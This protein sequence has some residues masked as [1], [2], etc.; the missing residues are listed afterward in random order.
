MAIVLPFAGSMASRPPRA[1]R[2][3]TSRPPIW[4]TRDWHN[5]R[6]R[7]PS[8]SAPGPS[9]VE[10]HDGRATRRHAAV[11]GID[12]RRSVGRAAAD[13]YDKQVAP[14]ERRAADAEEVFDDVE[15]PHRVDSPHLLAVC[16]SHALQHTLGADRVHQRSVDDGRG[17]RAVVVA[18]QVGVVGRVIALPQCVR[19]A[20]G[21]KHESRPASP[22]RAK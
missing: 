18:E 12:I 1:N 9:T 4:P 11:R 20:L 6:S 3:T 7:R 13:V 21:I 10:C 17:P 14:H 19:A 5:W 16:D 22:K 15:V 8:S 2:N